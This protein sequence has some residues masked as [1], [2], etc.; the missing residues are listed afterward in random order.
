MLTDATIQIL[1]DDTPG[2]AEL[3]H[4]NHSG[5][6][7]PPKRVTDAVVSHLKREALR[8]PM[9]AAAQVADRLST[10]RANAT[11]LIGAE[12]GEI[13]FGTSGSAV[14]GMVFA[15]LPPLRPGD[16]ILVGRQEWGGNVA[17][18][19]RAVARAGATLEV[20]P[21]RDDGS[22]DADA[23]AAM[24]DDKVRLISLTWLP[25]NGGLINDAEA[26]GKIAN[27]AGIPYLVDAGQA[28]GQVPID[29]AKIGCDV[30]KAAGRK[31]IRGPRGTALLY[32]RSTFLETLEPVFL[33]VSSGPLVD[34][35][36][37]LRTDARLFET[38]EA[39]VALHMGLGEAITL[40]SEL[41]IDAI[42]NRI[43][44]LSAILRQGLQAVP[45]VEVRDLGTRQ[46]G[47]VSF[48]VEGVSASNVKS[49][50]AEKSITI[51]ANGVAYTP[52][53]MT[54]R[55][56]REIARASVSYFNT[57]GEVTRLVEAVTQLARI[58]R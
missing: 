23:L 38:S 8:G 49:R 10:L 6:S 31:Y 21:C 50:L 29:V 52:F 30:L 27:A 42:H 32:I 41:G 7:L 53:D 40:A 36:P 28:L 43:G 9:E 57:V 58:S 56:L 25:A 54:A 15:A 13:A 34:W 37:E 12:A 1:R 4:F 20:I 46:S 48:T 51:G 35:M 44:I 22:V 2:C 3:I 45:G 18:M 19:Q 16:R 55:G 33:D 5:A 14:W 47:L 24:I 39:S 17:T 11:R 26:I